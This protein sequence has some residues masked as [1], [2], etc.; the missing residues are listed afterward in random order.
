MNIFRPQKPYVFRPPRYSPL[1]APFF[2]R[3]SEVL[4][5]RRKF[6]IRTITAQGAERIAA[7]SREG[8]SILVCPNHADHADPHVLLRIGRDHNLKFHFMAAREGFETKRWHAFVM[9][10]C[11]AFSVD[12][13]GADI[14]AFK[15]AVNILREARFPLVVFPEG[16]IYH[17]HE[18]LDPLNEGVATIVL[19]AASK[20][21]DDRKAYLVPTAMRYVYEK[22]VDNT[23]SDRLDA[24]EER[25]TW[26]PRSKMDVVD[27]IYRLGGGLLALK[28]V[29]FLSQ[30][31]DGDLIERILNLRN[32]LVAMIEEK[33]LQ[34]EGKGGIPQRVKAM[35]SRIR[36]MLTDSKTKLSGDEE[37]ELYD[38]LDTLF[39]AVQLYSYPGQYLREEPSI[40]RIAE[41]ILKLEEDV[42]GE[43]VYATPRDVQV[44][45]GE[46]IEVKAFLK[47]RSLNT[48]TG[49]GPLTE[50]LSGN[51]KS[52][53]EDL[54]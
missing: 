18:R 11:G 21:S 26:K 20:S 53:L 32:K 39:M 43:A 50:I 2:K 54:Q 37:G 38:D 41:T 16:E 1:L 15:A 12:R 13:E 5:L 17:H 49:V 52:M 46:P 48:K 31:Q 33:H 14:A 34:Q 24:L 51:I 19:R 29:E 35:R 36:T 22:S 7:L 8:H 45:F 3:V 40:H 47:N 9:Q 27:R 25:I 6:R 44:R 42:L 28:E 23:F 30:R 4:Y 10:C